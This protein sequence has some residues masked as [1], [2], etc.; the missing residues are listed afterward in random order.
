VRLKKAAVRGNVDPEAFARGVVDDFVHEL[1]PEQNL[2]THER[3]HA[4]GR[5]MQPVERCPGELLGH[6]LHP[7]VVRVAVVAIEIALVLGEQVG[8][9]RME[10]AGQQP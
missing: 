10:I 2:A 3:E 8:D 7:I 5:G 6:P 4:A 1:G 9:D